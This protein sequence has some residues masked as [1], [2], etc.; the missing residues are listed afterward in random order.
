[1]AA[2]RRGHD[3]EHRL[4]LL[5]Q[6]D[7]AVLELAGGESLGVDVGQL[8]ELESALHGHRE[9]DVAAQEQHRG[10]VGHPAGQVLDLV[11][12]VQDGLDLG[13]DAVQV[14]QDVLD[15]AGEQLAAQLAQVEAQQVGGGDH[16][17]EG[18]GGGHCDLRT[19]VQVEH[20]V[21]LARD[22]GSVGVAD[23]QGPGALLLG[24]A[25]GHEGVHGLAGLGDGHHQGGLVD[26]RVAVAELVGELHLHGNAG[27]VLDRVLGDLT[28]VGGGAAGQHD[29]L[30]GVL[31]L[32]RIDAQLIQ[33]QAALG[34]GAPQQ[35]LLHGLGLLVDLLLHEGV[36]AALLRG[37]GVPVD[38]EALALSGG[39]VEVDDGHVIGG[40]GDDLVLLQLDGLTSEVDEPGDVGSQEV[41]ALA[42]ADDQRGVAAGGDHPVGLIGVDGQQGEGTLELV[43]GQAHGLGEVALGLAGEAAADQLGCDLGVRLGLEGVTLGPQLLLE[44]GEVLD[45]AVVD[46][47]ELGL[48][49]QVRV[50]VLVGGAAMGGPAGVTDA[51]RGGSHRGL[52]DLVDEVH[53]L[54]GLLPSFDPTSGDRC[55]T[56]R[57]IAAVLQAPQP[58]QQH[59]Q[60]LMLSRLLRQT[61]VA[62]NSTH[63]F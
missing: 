56:G 28:G 42:Q 49:G 22:G 5:D 32:L 4:A 46:H 18:L 54:P 35:G 51:Q 13:R 16:G 8:L 2:V 53:Q 30:G 41:L 40:D 61:D 36:I 6:R 47:G 63:A 62:N 17:Q 39:A 11:G 12:V 25:D 7:R 10:G 24:V 44:L 60:S 34:V 43:G 3:D 27:P 59:V 33:G 29:D 1:M 26:D 57:V 38:V 58:F 37:G 20:G 23:G 45:D 19:G 48:V 31:Q 14:G 52:L 21:G 15:L 9:A 50:R 55:H